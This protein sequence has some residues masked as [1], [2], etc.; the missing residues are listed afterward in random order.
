MGFHC[1]PLYIEQNVR[2]EV[3]R[4]MGSSTPRLG[5][6]TP[7][8]SLLNLSGSQIP[9]KPKRKAKIA[10]AI[11]KYAG[12]KKGWVSAT[13]QKKLVVLEYMGPD[14]PNVFT[15][16]DKKICVRG[17]LP[18]NPVDA[19]ESEVRNEICDV[20][21][22]CSFPDL[23]E[24]TP[25]D[26]EFIDMSGKQARVPQCKAGFE[27]GGRALK[28][29]AGSG[30]VYVRLT[31]DVGDVSGA[32]SDDEFPPA[33]SAP[34]DS[35]SSLCVPTSNATNAGS[36]PSCSG[37][38]IASNSATQSTFRAVSHSG[39]STA[40]STSS[41]A[42]STS[43]SGA[44]TSH[45]VAS[46]SSSVD[47]ICIDDDCVLLKSE[48]SSPATDIAKLIEMFS[49]MNESQLK[50]LYGLSNCSF[51]STVDCALGGPSLESLRSLALTQ[52]T[53]PLE[54]SPRIWLDKEDDE[55][56]WVDA[57]LAF[58]K[59]AKFSKQAYVRISIR[60]QPGIDTGGVRRQFFSVVFSML[61]QSST[62]FSFFEGLPNRLRPAFKASTLSSGMLTTIG[63]MIAHSILL[64]GQGFPFFADYC[65]Y[66]MA[67]C[68][69]HAITCITPEDVGAGVNNILS[70]VCLSTFLLLSGRGKTSI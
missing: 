55:Q 62:S 17:L 44:S 30:C 39:P 16:T 28:E 54:E 37:S 35:N 65:F 19:S 9:K 8:H 41:S 47:P 43:H 15:R 52:L 32:S 27:W 7:T 13:F 10:L 40:A 26:F 70:G 59:Q 42:A 3:R 53:I 64:D 1:I 60:G 34:K 21:C 38:S 12:K 29:L 49:N 51:S 11:E 2:S 50:Y 20:V 14:A 25:N 33:F 57:A 23:T 18:A 61:A 46:T 58:Y 6:N 69:D 45:S 4:V 31:K 5:Y 48:A 24:C 22:T 36:H 66:Y 67:G 56:D 63:T 68:Y